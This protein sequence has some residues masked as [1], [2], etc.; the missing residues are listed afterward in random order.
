[1]A[2]QGDQLADKW[3]TFRAAERRLWES[4]SM[5]PTER[6]LPLGN[7]ARIRVQEVGEGLPMIFIHGATNGG[8]SWVPLLAHLH[9]VRAIAIDRPGCGLSEPV[10]S[11]NGANRFRTLEEIHAYTE[12]LLIDVLDAL[13]LEQAA[14]GATSYGGLFA[15]RAAAAHPDRVTKVVEYSWPMGAPMD[16]VPVLI[17][18]GA[19]P[20]LD[21]IMA[22][23]P[24]TRS[25]VKMM[26][27]Q[28]GLKAALTNGAFDDTML[29][30]FVALLQETDTMDNELR[31]APRLFRPLAGLDPDAVLSA[32][33]LAQVVAPVLLLWGTDDPNG[34][35]AIARRFAS[36]LPDA[37]LHLLPG[38]G[39]APWVDEPEECAQR[40]LAFLGVQG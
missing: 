3:P 8:A 18:I 40:T 39:H 28:I 30:W 1:M 14:V 34:G 7:G 36:Q 6:F 15:F 16:K 37:T 19:I 38:A 27:R 4:H 32:E 13:E 26:L 24:P 22:K 5:T 33:F 21:R 2:A 31:T 25:G 20:G 12:Q 10:Q 23:V 11:I 17:R 9:G 35:E 29:D